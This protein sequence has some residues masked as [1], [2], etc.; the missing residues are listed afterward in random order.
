MCM[1][2][3]LCVIII[4]QHE[5]YLC[6]Q[7]VVF[8]LCTFVCFSIS[9]FVLFVFVL[10]CLVTPGLSKDILCHVGPYF[11]YKQVQISRS[12]IRPHIK[13]AV[14]LVILHMV[15]SISFR[16]LCGYIWVNILTFITPEGIYKHDN[17]KCYMSGLTRN[18]IGDCLRMKEF[19]FE[20]FFCRPQHFGVPCIRLDCMLVLSFIVPF[21]W[22]CNSYYCIYSL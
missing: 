16:G 1:L 13:W 20:C 7:K 9:M 8:L 6:Q 2:W 15:T 14:S 17:V 22:R 3:A 10:C 21:D 12:D 18:L 5:N 4:K 11:L 19:S